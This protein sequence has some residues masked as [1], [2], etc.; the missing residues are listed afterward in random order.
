MGLAHIL[1]NLVFRDFIVSNTHYL[2]SNLLQFKRRFATD[3]NKKDENR[4]NI[5]S[6]EPDFSGY[7]KTTGD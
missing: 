5:A 6:H 4:G 1:Y 2:L 3:L 7:K